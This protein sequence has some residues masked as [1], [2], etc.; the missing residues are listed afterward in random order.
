M[1]YGGKGDDSVEGGYGNDYLFLGE[2]NDYSGVSSGTSDV[3]GSQYLETGDDYISGGD[4]DDIILDR[5]GSNTLAGDD[6]ND[7]IY[8]ADDDDS[9]PD[10]LLGGAGNDLIFTDDGDTITGGTGADAIEQSYVSGDDPVVVTDFDPAE[11]AL[12]I[13]VQDLTDAEVTAD[14]VETSQGVTLLINGEPVSIIQGVTIAELA[15][16]DIYYITS[17]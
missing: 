3:T 7:I 17:A 6:G 2:G 9:T 14:A 10:V 8:G 16:S 4:G 1:I 15:S 11:D 13:Y 12:N 5:L